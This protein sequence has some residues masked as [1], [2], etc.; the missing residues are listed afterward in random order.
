M[1]TWTYPTLALDGPEGL[2]A[3]GPE[4]PKIQELRSSFAAPSPCCPGTI[5]PLSP[6]HRKNPTTRTR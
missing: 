3:T 1:G 5:A 6:E 4:L 2:L